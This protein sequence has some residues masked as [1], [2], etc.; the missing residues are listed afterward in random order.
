VPTVLF[1]DRPDPA[2]LAKRIK[3]VRAVGVAGTSRAM[4]PAQM[5]EE[6]PGHFRLLSGLGVP[7]IHYRFVR[8]STP[9]RKSAAS[10]T[11]RTSP[12]P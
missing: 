5:D 6:L 1:L 9:P 3:E 4:T 12:L 11:P 2:L 8:P 10:A 7:F